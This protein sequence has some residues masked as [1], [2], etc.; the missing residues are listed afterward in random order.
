MDGLDLNFTIISFTSLLAILDPLA[1][2]P[3]YLTL[4]SRDERKR[5]HDIALTTS[6][7]VLVT[8]TTFAFGGV[9]LLELLG[10]TLPAFRV[11]GGVLL[12]LMALQMLEGRM[13]SVKRSE[14]V[15]DY[16]DLRSYAIVPLAIP[17][18][19]GPGAMSATVLLSQQ[20]GNWTN[21]TVLVGVIFF[22]SIL[23]YITL[24]LAD[25]AE[26]LLGKTGIRIATRVMG[27]LLAAIAMQ[28]IVS[29]LQ[30][31]FP[32]LAVGASAGEP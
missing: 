25:K 22:C 17:L 5:S 18:L 1:V 27:L 13:S 9:H 8:L 7:A 14:G 15:E 32:A 6:L 28:F 4:F 29:G 23:I 30:E 31:L 10:V 11:S 20:A 16:S 26:H 24:R 3:I 2:V 19:S 21:M 12:F